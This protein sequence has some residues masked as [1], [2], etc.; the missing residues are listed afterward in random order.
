MTSHRVFR[1]GAAAV[2][3]TL[4]DCSAGDLT[5]PGPGQ[6]G[7]D[8]PAALKV[9][10]GDGQRGRS[11]NASSMTRSRSRCWTRAPIRSPDVQVQ[12]SFLGDLFGRGPRPGIDRNRRRRGVPR[13]SFG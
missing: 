1:M 5:L 8:Q 11:W 2:M 6:S 13:R 9:L 3:L 7:A 10:S 4:I 12:F